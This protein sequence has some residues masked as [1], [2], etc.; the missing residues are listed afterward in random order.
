MKCDETETRN[1]S[2]AFDRFIKK[3]LGRVEKLSEL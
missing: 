2:D 3:T 1:A